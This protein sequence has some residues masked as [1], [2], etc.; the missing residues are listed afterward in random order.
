MR[1]YAV[2]ILLIWAGISPAIAGPPGLPDGFQ[3]AG[4]VKVQSVVDG[5]TVALTDG[6]QVRLVGIQAPKLSLGRDHVKDWP[7]AHEAKAALAKLVAGRAITLHRG[8]TGEDRHGR[9]LAHLVRAPDHLWLQGEMLRLGL[10]RVYTFPDNR[11]AAADM[12]ALEHQARQAR[13]GIWAHPYYAIRTPDTVNRRLDRFEIV[14]GRIRAVAEVKGRLYLNFGDDWRDDFTVKVE[15]KN[16]KLF[17]QAALDLTQWNGKLVR[18]RG[19]V[20]W[21]NGPLINATHPEQIELL[22][23]GASP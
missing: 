1:R 23:T 17:R 9:V 14:E 20:T 8:E 6:R 2:I 19:W 13:R 18:V 12:L 7:L 11:R 22:E 21:Q 3:A 5:D 15:R 16:R 10:A 4:Q